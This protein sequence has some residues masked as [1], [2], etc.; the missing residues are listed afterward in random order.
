MVGIV[1]VNGLQSSALYYKD[2][3]DRLWIPVFDVLRT[4]IH[5]FE[6]FGPLRCSHRLD[7]LLL[8]GRPMDDPSIVRQARKPSNGRPID[9]PTNAGKPSDGRPI[10]RPTSS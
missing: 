4:T 10:D 5:V 8:I 6:L 7:V 3:L 2:G 1:A 9:R